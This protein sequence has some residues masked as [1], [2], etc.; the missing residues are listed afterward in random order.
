MSKILSLVISLILLVENLP[1]FWNPV[2]E[3]D[4]AK[5]MGEVTTKATGFLYGLAEPGVPSE[6]I[7][8]S[9]DI[10]S[11]SQKVIGGL[12]HP[13]GDAD[14]LKD[15]LTETD[16]IVVY[17]Q[18]AFDTWYYAWEEIGK[19]RENGTYDW[20]EYITETYFPIVREK[21]TAL[22]DTDYADKLV[23]CIYNEC[24]NGVWFGNYVDGWAQYDEIGRQNFY[25]GWKMT[26]DLVKSLDPDAMIGGP[27]FCDYET[28]KMEGFMSYCAENDCVPEIMI[29]HELADWS[30]TDWKMHVD[31]YRRIENEN[32]V[33][34]LPIIVTEYGTMEQCGNPSQMIHYIY[35]IE[36]TGTYGNM[37]YWRLSNNLNDT[38][39]DD[40]TP[41][42]N[43]W[44]YRKY[45]EMDGQLLE[46]KVD[47]L[48][49][50]HK[51]DGNWRRDYKGIASI[52]DN[53]DEIN[54]LAVGS[55]NARSIEIKNLK[56]TNLGKKVDVKV[57]CVYY[58]GLNTPTYAPITLRQYTVNTKNKLTINIPGTDTDAVYFVT[59]TPHDEETKVIRN[60]NIPVRYEFEEG[61]L[62][63]TAYTYD[64][65]YATTG[66]IQ[67]MVGGIEKI[68]DG[69]RIKIKAPEKGRYKLDI[70][71]GKHND[72]GVPQGR[73]FATANFTLDGK[74][75]ELKL[76]NTIKS[77]YTSLYSM[78]LDLS[79][80]KHTIEF[81][82]NDGTYVLD[83]MLLYK[84]VEKK[85]IEVLSDSEN[86]TEFLAVAPYDGWF[87]IYGTEGKATA[88]FDGVKREIENGTAVYLR[89]GL[90][91]IKLSSP[92]EL[93][94]KKTDKTGFSA[95]ITAKEMALS[96][97]AELITD[98]YGNTFVDSISNL[99]GKAE[100]IID[101][102]EKG[103]YRVTLTYANNA[104]GGV[105]SYNVD[106]IERYA[107]F[108]VNGESQ[109]V[110]CRNTFSRYNFKTVTFTLSLEKGENAVSITNSGS[111]LFNGMTAYAPQI[112]SLTVNG[113]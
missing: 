92:A 105:H 13:T 53:K 81:T 103:D 67:G 89:R 68:G 100:F 15:Q 29:Y 88:D 49:D 57:E 19:M 50:R 56:E 34:E 82:H 66:E 48:K 28:T 43:W 113:K 18:D 95:E 46:V 40:N 7:T 106:L 101:A 70:I 16:Y 112:A 71:Y 85:D 64:S 23:Y 62:L 26:Y 35:E 65:A 9:L 77:E 98:K 33:S 31:D 104:E 72:S 27:G 3:I 69:V 94:I 44:L 51:H 41:N 11:V 1:L 8:D 99:G 14:R 97:G 39:A 63:G 54:I 90:N 107:T 76:P 20:K 58:N 96:D 73:D 52:T 36:R 75:T 83:S 110:Y 108:T 6:A 79:M 4:A 2:L 61:K 74:T 10:S 17:L 25:E 12:Q 5:P 21:V 80:G 60:Q 91:E 22:R 111:Y 55:D 37:A 45:A 24:D 47:S 102:P 86:N 109:D 30:T 32:G 59:V 93:K 87:E 78:T 38:T 84:D 42:S